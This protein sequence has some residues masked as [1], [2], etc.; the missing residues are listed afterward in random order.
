MRVF[1]KVEVLQT[2]IH[3]INL[4]PVAIA[5]KEINKNQWNNSKFGNDLSKTERIQREA[6]EYSKSLTDA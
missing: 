4:V 3:I 2:K 5:K 1:T 6:V